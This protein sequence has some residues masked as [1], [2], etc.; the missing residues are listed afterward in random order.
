MLKEYRKDTLFENCQLCGE[1]ILDHESFYLDDGSY[2]IKGYCAHKECVEEPTPDMPGYE[3]LR[4]EM[5][6]NMHLVIQADKTGSVTS[7]EV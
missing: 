1:K 3:K 7:D 6:E 4:K 2:F 5:R